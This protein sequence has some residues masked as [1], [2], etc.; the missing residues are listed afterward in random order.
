MIS[1]FLPLPVRR[2]FGVKVTSRPPE[3]VLIDQPGQ[4]A[5]LLAAL[6]R[7]DEVALDTEADNMFHYRTRVCLLQFLVGREIFLVDVLAPLP[8][9]GLWARL[10]EKNLIM[11]GSDFDLRL[12]HDF[13]RF[14]PKSIFDTMLAAQLINRPRIGLAS[15]LEDHFGVKLSKESQKANW[16]KRPL[17]KKMLDY[18]ALDVFHL[19]AL[20]DILTRELT[21]LGR[22]EWLRQ[23]CRAQI[24]AGSIGFA[25][26]DENDWRIGR[27][28][29]LRGPGLGV[30]HAVWHWREQTAQRLDVPPFKVCSADLLLRLAQAAE[31]GDAEAAI[32]A[33]VH[34]GRR[35]DRLLPSLTAAVHAGLARDPKTLPRRRGRDPNHVA[36]TQ[37]EI[38][39]LDRIKDDRDR[40][41]AKLQLEPTL[42]ANRSQLAQIA[43]APDRL[44]DL[45][46]PWQAELLRDQPSFKAS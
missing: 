30:L 1:R 8:F 45:L 23:Q 46:L 4:L 26:P 15:L 37:A 6:D 25:P 41:A 12:L 34:L 2:L 14:R 24:E 40:I 32:L 3:Y 21:K 13:C 18:A 33:S 10:A 11:H 20:R 22:I 44:D 19:P 7:V 9:E 39:R 31:N 28:E 29:K 5:P 35:H 17:T 27:S 43:R 36:L 38:E 42:I 16:S